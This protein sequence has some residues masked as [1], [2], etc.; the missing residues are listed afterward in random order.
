MSKVMWLPADLRLEPR[1]VGLLA[2]HSTVLLCL[3]VVWR[4]I[5][6]LGRIQRKLKLAGGWRCQSINQLLSPSRMDGLMR[7]V[8]DRRG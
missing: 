4:A 7:L 1:P 6:Y 8:G 3:T 2:Q 5:L